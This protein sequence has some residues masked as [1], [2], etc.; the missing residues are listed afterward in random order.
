MS[1]KI[2][3]KKS[4]DFCRIQDLRPGTEYC[5]CVTAWLEGVAGNA[6]EPTLIRTPPCEPDP[7]AMPKLITRTRTALQLRWVA[8]TDNGAAIT[9]YVLECEQPTGT[10]A[11]MYRGKGKQSNL[12]KLQPATC[13][14][15]RLCAINECG[16]R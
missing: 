8:T 13:Y 2:H 6:S 10:W 12:S 9:H 11:E 5:V 16:K 4:F 1:H 15:F 7:P 14:K 3:Y